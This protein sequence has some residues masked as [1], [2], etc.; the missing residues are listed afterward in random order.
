MNCKWNN[1]FLI[2]NNGTSKYATI[3]LDIFPSDA[4]NENDIMEDFPEVQFEKYKIIIA[5]YNCFRSLIT[6]EINFL[7][8]MKLFTPIKNSVRFRIIC[9]P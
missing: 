2:K 4:E 1:V 6:V 7:V 5:C 3:L 8:E 9:A